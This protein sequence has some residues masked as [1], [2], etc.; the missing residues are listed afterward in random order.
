MNELPTQSLLDTRNIDFKWAYTLHMMM[1]SQKVLEFETP[2]NKGEEVHV[3]NNP[4]GFRG[5]IILW[6]EKNEK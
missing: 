1:S 2:K 3:N 6:G 4:S 5:N